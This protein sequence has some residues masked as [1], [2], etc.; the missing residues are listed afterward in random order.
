MRGFTLIEIL[1]VIGVLAIIVASA[2]PLTLDFYN[3]RQ[4]DLYEQGLVQK[5]RQAQTKAMETENDSDFGV[6]LT[7]NEYVLFQGSSYSGR[8]T[9]LDETIDLPDNLEVTGMD[10]IIFDKLS[11]KPSQTREITLKIGAEKETLSINEVGMVSY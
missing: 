11:G 10:E 4:L 8:D 2:T 5:L 1:I 9:N 7:S 3:S 6:Y